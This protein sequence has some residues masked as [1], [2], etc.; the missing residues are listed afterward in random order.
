[1]RVTLRQLSKK[2]ALAEAIRYALARW[3]ALLVRYVGDGRIEIDNN[4]AGRASRA[5]V[6]G[7]FGRFDMLTNKRIQAEFY[8]WLF[9]KI[10][11]LGQVTPGA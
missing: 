11:A 2:S 7:R 3:Q 9:D 8:R 10:S 4:A 6:L 1:M 5:V